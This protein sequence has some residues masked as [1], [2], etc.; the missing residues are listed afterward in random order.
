[1]RVGLILRTAKEPVKEWQRNLSIWHW[2]SSQCYAFNDADKSLHCTVVAY[3][4]LSLD[5]QM[6]SERWLNFEISMSKARTL[7]QVAAKV[8]LR[9][10]GVHWESFIAP[11]W[12]HITMA[13]AAAWKFAWCFVWVW[14]GKLEVGFE[15][16]QLL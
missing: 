14:V 16:E 7:P 6:L 9:T 12:C 5:G 2:C 11:A 3:Y 15:P 8:W 4:W 1:M 10:L 13:E